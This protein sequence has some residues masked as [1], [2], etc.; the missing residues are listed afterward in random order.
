MRTIDV[1]AR[2]EE[3]AWIVRHTRGLLWEKYVVGHHVID[4]VVT[5]EH[6]SSIRHTYFYRTGRRVSDEGWC[7]DSDIFPT[8]KQAQAEADRRNREGKG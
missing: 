3:L 4:R 1:R 5:Y 2:P 6:K 8:R 7:Y